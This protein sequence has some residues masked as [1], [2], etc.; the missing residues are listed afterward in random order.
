MLA[1]TSFWWPKGSVSEDFIVERVPHFVAV[2]RANV[3]ETNSFHRHVDQWAC[4]RELRAHGN[5][6][7][8]P[9]GASAAEVDQGYTRRRLV[10]LHNVDST[11]FDWQIRTSRPPL[12]I[13]EARDSIRGGVSHYR[14]IF[15]SPFIRWVPFNITFM[16]DP[17][18][19]SSSA[20]GFDLMYAEHVVC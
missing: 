9:L 14:E 13:G 2:Q 11:L 8:A 15:T 7:R 4:G 1:S 16:C 5:R 18:S 6:S 3:I 12:M 17:S 10:L 20:M 19:T